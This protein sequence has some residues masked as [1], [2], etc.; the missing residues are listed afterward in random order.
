MRDANATTMIR[1]MPD[2]PSYILKFIINNTQAAI[3]IGKE[4]RVPSGICSYASA[5]VAGQLVYCVLIIADIT[6]IKLAYLVA[7]TQ[8]DALQA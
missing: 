4:V 3:Y 6:I 8:P 5:V 2:M 7:A 1:F